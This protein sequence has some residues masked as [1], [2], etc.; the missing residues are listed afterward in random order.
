MMN[1]AA[2][3]SVC[4]AVR[5]SAATYWLSVAASVGVFPRIFTCTPGRC[6]CVHHNVDAKYK[7]G[8]MNSPKVTGMEKWL[9]GL[10]LESSLCVHNLKLRTIT[11]SRFKL[12]KS[13]SCEK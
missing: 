7:P 4:A 13:T 9:V 8:E 10:R 12:L 6:T 3:A 11:R 2:V 1:G 5:D